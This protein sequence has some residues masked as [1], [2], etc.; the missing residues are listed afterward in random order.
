MKI[1]RDKSKLGELENVELIILN[2]DKNNQYVD[3]NQLNVD[4]NQSL[5]SICSSSAT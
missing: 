2:V 4:K 5:S 1:M 3:R